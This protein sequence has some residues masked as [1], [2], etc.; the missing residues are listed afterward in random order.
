MIELNKL[1][2]KEAHQKLT[3]KEIS[4]LELTNA[5]IERIKKTD[6]KVHAFLATD[7]DN[8]EKQAKEVDK[9]IK[10]G[11]KIKM[12]EGIPCSIKDM[13]ITKGIATTA[14]SNMLRNYVP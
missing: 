3:D 2:I 14:S 4:S 1:T 7:F 11:E 10:K 13:I 12:L 6:K 9:K 8:A 5:C